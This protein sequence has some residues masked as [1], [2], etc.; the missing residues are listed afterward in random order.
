MKWFVYDNELYYPSAEI[1]EAETAE[2]ALDVYKLE[3]SSTAFYG[4]A[5]F[6]L[7][8]LHVWDCG[9]GSKPIDV[10]LDSA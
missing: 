2:A 1:V 3:N 4:I 8:A 9:D 6:P 10:V 5:V 7:D